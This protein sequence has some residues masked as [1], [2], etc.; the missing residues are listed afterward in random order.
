V[1]AWRKLA[2]EWQIDLSRIV[3]EVSLEQLNPKIDEIL[4]GGIRGRVLVN[5]SK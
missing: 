4:K 3:T 2:G 1:M 5:L